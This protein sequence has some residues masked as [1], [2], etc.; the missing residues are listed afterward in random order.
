MNKNINEPLWIKNK[1]RFPKID[2]TQADTLKWPP[3][4]KKPHK[5]QQ[6][7]NKLTNPLIVSYLV[8]VK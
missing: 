6:R 5:K 2:S 4:K 7:Y 8:Q 3:P 1:W